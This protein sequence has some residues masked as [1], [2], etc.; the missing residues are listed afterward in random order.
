MLRRSN[1]S[2]A[3]TLIELLVVI[4]IIAILAGLL[5]PALAKAKAKGQ[6]ISCI[7]NLKQVGL[8]FIMW[9]DDNEGRFPWQLE[10]TNG[11]SK[12]ISYAWLHFTLISNEISTPKVLRCASDSI[13]LANGFGTGSGDLFGDSSKQDKALSYFIGTEARPTVPLMHLAGDRNL[14]GNDGPCAPAGIQNALQLQTTGTWKSDIH[15]NAGNFA[16]VDGSA[17]QI[18]QSGLKKHL[19][20]PQLMAGDPNLSNCVLP[21]RP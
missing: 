18:S 20:Q 13:S 1:L 8:S 14:N 5:L 3:F 21:P 9:S 12:S 6:R 2:R 4:A 10:I 17:Q 7:S 19:S 15:G 16:M 11:G